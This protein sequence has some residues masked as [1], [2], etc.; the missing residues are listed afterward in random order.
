[1]Y[2]IVHRVFSWG[3]SDDNGGLQ[4]FFYL[5]SLLSDRSNSLLPTEWEQSWQTT[6][7]RQL[8]THLARAKGVPSQR[9]LL[10]RHRVCLGI[11]PRSERLSY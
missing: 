11:L 1:M 9:S 5:Q 2:D 10:S 4:T 6:S 8:D 3:T 7:S